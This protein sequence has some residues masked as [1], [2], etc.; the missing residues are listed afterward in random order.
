[1][2][3]Y[4]DEESG[5]LDSALWAAPI[6]RTVQ[7]L[8]RGFTEVFGFILLMERCVLGQPGVHVHPFSFIKH[9]SFTTDLLNLTL[10]GTLITR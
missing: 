3:I 4:T 8:F 2:W 7:C 10:R 5:S 1:M 9:N 6:E